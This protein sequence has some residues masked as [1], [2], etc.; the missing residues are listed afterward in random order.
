MVD[1]DVEVKLKKLSKKGKDKSLGN[2]MS[3]QREDI[4]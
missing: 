3:S 4:S 1:G 2:G